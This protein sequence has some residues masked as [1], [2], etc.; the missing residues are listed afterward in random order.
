MDSLI[1]ASRSPRRRKILKEL[2]I[3]FIIS[4]PEMHVERP[5]K[6]NRCIRQQVIRNS[7]EKALNVSKQFTNGL[8]L[9]VDTVVLIGSRVF[10]K[11]YGEDEA[12]KYLKMLSG[13]MHNVYSGITLIEIKNQRIISGFANTEVYFKKLSSTEIDNYINSNEW[14][15]KAGGYA[16]QGKASFFIREIKGSFYNVVGLPVELL[17]DILKRFNYFENNGKYRPLRRL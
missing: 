2:E 15:D 3:P 6:G 12:R 11:P 13:R 16:I 1:L 4:Q 8:I 10:E 5:V 7:R 9:G 14:V 17:Y